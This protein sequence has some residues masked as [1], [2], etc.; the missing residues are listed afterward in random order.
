MRVARLARSTSQAR[1]VRCGGGMLS[2]A[3]SL[4]SDF[5]SMI[6]AV[7][8]FGQ[9]SVRSPQRVQASSKCARRRFS[10]VLTALLD[11]L[12]QP[13]SLAAMGIAISP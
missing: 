2:F 10:S 11:S 8:T 7:F 13:A 6:A 5:I 3:A 12:P 4:D 9:I 1:C